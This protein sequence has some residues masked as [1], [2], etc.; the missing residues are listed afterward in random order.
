MSGK[1]TT[2]KSRHAS[3]FMGVSLLVMLIS[4]ILLLSIYINDA[5]GMRYW[6][7]IAKLKENS[8]EWSKDDILPQYRS[9]YEQNPDFIGWLSIEGTKIDYPVMQTKDDPEYY[10]RQN[11]NREDDRS[12][13]P[14]ADY[15]CDILPYRSFN[16]IIYGHRTSDGSMFRWLLNY[17]YKG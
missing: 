1:N 13:T 12:G 11:F 16:T 15:R 9:L 8:S 4:G 5:K 3:V 7:K 6:Q 14:F 10:L 2:A 17:A